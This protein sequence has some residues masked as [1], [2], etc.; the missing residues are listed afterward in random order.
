MA[1]VVVSG[2]GGFG[3]VGGGGHAPVGFGCGAFGSR[4][5]FRRGS[6]RSRFRGRLG[7]SHGL[8]PR[9]FLCGGL[10][11][12]GGGVA[13]VSGLGSAPRGA[14]LWL[15]LFL[16]AVRLL[17]VS[18]GSSGQ[19]VGNPGSQAPS[20]TVLR[21]LMGYGVCRKGLVVAP[22]VGRKLGAGLRLP[23]LAVSVGEMVCEPYFY[24]CLSKLS[25]LSEKNEKAYFVLFTQRGAGGVCAKGLG[26]PPNLRWYGRVGAGALHKVVS[27]QAVG[28]LAPLVL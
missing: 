26:S 12:V 1:V 13:C 11:R 18:R 15:A 25:V 2:F 19:D 20:P 14:V 7:A 16:F 27:R 28:W 5:P 8:G 4:R 22:C 24:F 21:D 23:G 9:L 10:P 3:G 17:C 6:P